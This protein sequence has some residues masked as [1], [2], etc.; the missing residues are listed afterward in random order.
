[1]VGAEAAQLALAV[2]DLAV[3]LVDQPQAGLERSLPGLG[4]PKPGEQLTAVDAEQIGDRA[5]LAVREQDRMDAYEQG[6]Y[7]ALY[8]AL[9]HWLA[10]E[11]PF[12]TPYYSNAEIPH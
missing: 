3:E 7:L 12:W 2:A 4:Q 9:Q 1:V 10:N 8:R 6:Q 11:F 5:G